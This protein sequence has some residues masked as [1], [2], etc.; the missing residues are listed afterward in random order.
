MPSANCNLEGLSMSV[1]DG[2]PLSFGFDVLGFLLGLIGLELGVA[3]NCV[4]GKER[5]M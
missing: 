1:K 2:E 5:R 4:W 3:W